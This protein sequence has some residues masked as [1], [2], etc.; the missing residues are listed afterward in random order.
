MV[1]MVPEPYGH[2]ALGAWRGESNRPGQNVVPMITNVFAPGG[3]G[4]AC[5]P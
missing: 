4:A 3:Y 2:V 1:T 5:V